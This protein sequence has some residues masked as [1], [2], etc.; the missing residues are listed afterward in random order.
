[1]V[2]KTENVIAVQIDSHIRRRKRLSK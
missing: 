2:L 1:M